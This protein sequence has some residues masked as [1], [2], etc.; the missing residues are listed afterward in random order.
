MADDCG[1]VGESH[2]GSN[3]MLL[4]CSSNK[5]TLTC[6]GRWPDDENRKVFWKFPEA[7]VSYRGCF[8]TFLSDKRGQKIVN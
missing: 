8:W 7:I 2:V 3:T 1:C 5:H 6:V 4:A